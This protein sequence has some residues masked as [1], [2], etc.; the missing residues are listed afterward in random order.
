MRGVGVLP[1]SP[2]LPLV[3]DATSPDPEPARTSSRPVCLDGAAGYVE[4]AVYD[5][6]ALRAGHVLT[7]PA[8]VEVPTT[9]V[10]IPAGTTATVDHLGNLT[11]RTATA[12]TAAG[13]L[14]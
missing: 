11:I 2:E 6:G 8:I 4:T 9:T 1:F 14:S 10:V 7:G 12:A 5:Y 3:P 13:S